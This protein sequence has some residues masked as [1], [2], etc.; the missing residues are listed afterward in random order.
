MEGRGCLHRGLLCGVL[1]AASVL[2]P[3]YFGTFQAAALELSTPALPGEVWSV[4]TH[5]EWGRVHFLT[6]SK[7]LFS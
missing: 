6:F 4:G 3:W 5:G 2:C 7:A 1:W